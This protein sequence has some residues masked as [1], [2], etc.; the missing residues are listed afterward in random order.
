LFISSSIVFQSAL[1]PADAFQMPCHRQCFTLA[2][3]VRRLFE[4]KQQFIMTKSGKS[5]FYFGIYAICAGLLFIIIPEKTISLLQLPSIQ[6]GWARVIGLLAIVIGVYD[7]LCG[8]TN[9][10]PF[11]KVS[12]YVRFG[13]AVSAILLYVF[14]QMS[15]CIILIGGIDA[16]GALWTAIALKS[17]ISK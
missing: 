9:I 6:G 16:L 10:R 5:L 11:I 3:M 4:C 1:V 8:Q 7:I 13:F 17:E 14:G 15:I 2:A 12:I